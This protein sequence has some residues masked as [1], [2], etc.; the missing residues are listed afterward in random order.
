MLKD[1][2]SGRDNDPRVVHV[3]FSKSSDFNFLKTRSLITEPSTE[4]KFFDIGNYEINRRLKGYTDTC[5]ITDKNPEE[6]FRPSPTLTLLVQDHL[7]LPT[8]EEEKRLN[9][10][11]RFYGKSPIYRFEIAVLSEII[12]K[13]IEGYLA[14]LAKRADEANVSITISKNRRFTPKISS[15]IIHRLQLDPYDTRPVLDQLFKELFQFSCDIN[16]VRGWGTIATEGADIVLTTNESALAFP[17]FGAL[18]EDEW[19]EL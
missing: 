4:T 14:N 19:N 18:N 12:S 7:E 16:R 8:E 11:R 15:E 3:A 13:E 9:V 2:V 5:K 6:L 17:S 1:A 10:I